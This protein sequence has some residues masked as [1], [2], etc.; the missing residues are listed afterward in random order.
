M[1]K[2]EKVIIQVMIPKPTSAKYGD[3][4]KYVKEAVVAYG[5]GLDPEHPLFG[6]QDKISVKRV[7]VG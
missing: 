1:P 2:A 7:V 6:I 5:G 3:L 4:V